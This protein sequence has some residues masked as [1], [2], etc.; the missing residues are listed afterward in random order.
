MKVRLG[1][2]LPIFEPTAEPAFSAA[3]EAEAEGLDGVFTYDHLW[4]LGNPGKPAIAAFPLLG[5]LCSR[6]SEIALGTLVARIGLMPEEYLL[7]AL[8]SVEALSG[9]RLIAGIGTGDHKNAP[10]NAAYG[11]AF[12]PAE[13]RREVLQRLALA[14]VASDV[15]TWIGGGAPATSVIARR[16]GCTLNLWGASPEAVAAEA[17]LGP[18]TWAGNLPRDRAR[19]VELLGALAT[20]GAYWIV[21]HWPGSAAALLEAAEAAGI[22]RFATGPSPR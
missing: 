8:L 14:L 5:A 20:A 6:T 18:V 12:S 9:G 19:A 3:A 21:V 7:Q 22:E 1:V 11:I 16:V 17:R 13:E 10:E 15:P 2:A 4:P